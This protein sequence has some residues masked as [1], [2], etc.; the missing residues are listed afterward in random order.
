M[1]PTQILN[2]YWV[3]ENDVSDDVTHSE[4]STNWE[5]WKFD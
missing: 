5:I 4:K 3:S 1:D 2:I